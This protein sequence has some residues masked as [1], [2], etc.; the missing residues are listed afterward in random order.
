MR[1]NS[2]CWA[3]TRQQTMTKL[4]EGKKI[5]II[6]LG[7][8]GGSIARGLSLLQ[9]DIEIIGVGRNEAVLQEALSDG[10]I[11]KFFT[12][13]KTACVD[14]DLVVIAVPSLTVEKILV[15]LKEVVAGKTVITDA[16]SV[17]SE[18]IDAVINTFG[19]VPFNFVP[20]HPIAGSE[21][22]TRIKK[23]S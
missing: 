6:G 17:K 4:L 9:K 20:G 22:S 5:V 13:I 11:S 7:L 23:L 10:V 15:E 18:I 12:E 8:I 16:A 19:K 14:A 1:L 2:G 3:H 21:H